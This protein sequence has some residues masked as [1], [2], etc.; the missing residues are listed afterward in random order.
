MSVEV[1]SE[2]RRSRKRRKETRTTRH[3]DLRSRRPVK[4]TIENSARKEGVRD[5]EKGRGTGRERNTNN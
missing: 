5:K 2:I 1:Q 3:G 4:R